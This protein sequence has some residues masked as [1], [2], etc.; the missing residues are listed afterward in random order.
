RIMGRTLAGILA[1]AAHGRFPYTATPDV[2][3]FGTFS[4]YAGP[5]YQN[6]GYCGQAYSYMKAGSSVVVDNYL[7]V[8]SCN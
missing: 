2:Q 5:V 7:T 8:G 3:D 6:R 4:S 1:G